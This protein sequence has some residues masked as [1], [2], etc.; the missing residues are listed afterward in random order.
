MKGWDVFRSLPPEQDSG[1]EAINQKCLGI[2]IRILKIF[3][4]VLC[5]VMILAGCVISKGTLFFM[6]SQIRPQKTT[7]YC[8]V[9]LERDRQ[10]Q[11]KNSETEQVVNF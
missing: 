8:N 1:S 10:Y 9:E 5:F 4:Y 11:T 2:I 7:L 3:T 6:T